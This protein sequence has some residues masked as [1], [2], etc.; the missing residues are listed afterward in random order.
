MIDEDGECPVAIVSDNGTEF[1]SNALLCW[2]GES[3]V[4]WKYIQPGKPVQNAFAESFVGRLRDKPSTICGSA[5]STT[6]VWCCK[7]GGPTIKA[8]GLTRALAGHVRS[9]S[10]GRCLWRPL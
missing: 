1:T 6:L 10:E 8:R 3:G 7:F 4:V 9:G 2:A 5:R